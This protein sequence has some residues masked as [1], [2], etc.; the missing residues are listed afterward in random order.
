[1]QGDILSFYETSTLF[2][3]IIGFYDSLEIPT[4]TAYPGGFL[5]HAK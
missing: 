5:D 2:Y 3:I 4:S 1:M